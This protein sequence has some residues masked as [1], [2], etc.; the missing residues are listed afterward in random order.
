MSWSAAPRPTTARSCAA[1][2]CSR[3][4]CCT[5]SATRRC[6][7]CSPACSSARPA[8]RRASTRPATTAST[9]SKSP[10]PRCRIPVQGDPRRCPG[11]STAC[12]AT[13]WPTSPAIPTAPKSAST[14][15]IRPMARPAASA[16]SS[17]AASR[18]RPMRACRSPSSCWSAP[19]SPATG[20][21]PLDGSFVRWG[22]T[23][24]DRFMLPHYVWADFLDVLADLRAHGFELD[25]DW[26]D[27]QLEFR[28]PFCGEVEY[29]GV[30]PRTA[31]GARALARHGRTRRHRR[32][33]PLRRLLGRAPAGQARRH[34]PR[35]LR[36]HL[37]PAPGA[38]AALPTPPEPPSPASATRP[39]SRPP[40]CTRRCRSTRR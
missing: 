16:W 31:P 26:F 19:S 23:L 20:P 3:A 36:R 18:C 2:T 21:N 33:R 38:A 28:F 5:G 24:H 30:Q 22:T 14:S 34:Q 37:Q 25:P 7:T 13:C 17:S 6:P 40:A 39:G 32:H 8:R 10:S 29:E 12:S 15:S 27:A 9:S 11:W 35:A 1:P 4:W